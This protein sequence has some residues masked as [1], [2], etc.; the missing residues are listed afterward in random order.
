MDNTII[1]MPKERSL[2]FTE[3][4]DQASVSSIS[5]KIIEINEDDDLL[6]EQASFIGFKYEPKP[7]KLYIDSYG[8]SIYQCLSLISVIEKSSTPVHTICMGA[9]MSAGFIILIS[10]HKRFAY[11]YS[12]PLY[13]QAS[14]ILFGTIKTIEEDVTQ[15]KRLQELIE[16]ITFERTKITKQRLKE[17]YEKKLDWYMTAQEA[18]KLSVV[19]EIL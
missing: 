18:L 6:L 9:A 3:Q 10:G 1:R 16:K 19:D 15:T 4:V 8:G 11:K 13:H 5:K 7:I 14:T 12:T 17:V 2:F